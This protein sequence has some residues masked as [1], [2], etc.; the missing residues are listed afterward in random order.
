MSVDFP[1]PALPYGVYMGGE[2]APHLCVAAGTDLI[3]LHAAADDLADAVAPALLRTGRLNELL[4]AGR[5][6]WSGLR[7]ALIE[8]AGNGSLDRHRRPQDGVE[9]HLAWEVADFVDFYSSQH[10]AEN[11]GR[12][13][14]P[15]AEPLLP[16]WRHLPVGYHGRSG[17]IFVDGTPVH[18]PRGQRRG[19]D[20]EIV[21]G[22]SVRLDMEAELGW[23]LGGATR[24]GETV[25]TTSAADHL[26]GIVILNDWSARDIQA[27]EYVPLGPFLGKSFATSVSAWVLPLDALDQSRREGPTQ[28]P[29]PLDYLRTTEPWAFDIELAAHLNGDELARVNAGDALYW[30]PAQQLAHMTVNGATVR[31][32]DLFGTGTI[33][34]PEPHQRGS[35]LELTWNGTEAIELPDGSTRTFLQDGDEVTLTA[36]A[37]DIP[38]G[39]VTGKV[40]PSF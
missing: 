38:L 26:F 13:F 10:H 20:G 16:N 17:T 2:G 34:G 28:N 3:D 14:R 1:L 6:T 37:G 4:A 22:P 31:P 40:L 12:M 36:R 39:P 29:Q 25:P 7:N 19:P 15:D 23:V 32:G 9:M 27:W 18:R 8:R 24:S 5:P 35:L 11:V 33:S 21:F 30:S